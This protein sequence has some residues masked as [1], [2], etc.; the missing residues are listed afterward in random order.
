MWKKICAIVI[1]VLIAAG[2]LVYMLSRVWD[3]IGTALAAVVPL[4]PLL[5]AAA[6]VICVTAWFLR[7]RR[8]KTILNRLGTTVSIPF[9]TAC[10][11]VSQTANIVVPARLGDF[12]R[13]FILK[14]EK[15]TTYTAGFTS[16]IAERVYDILTIALLG[17]VSLPFLISLI[18]SEYSWFSWIIIGVLIMGAMGILFLLF[19]RNAHT[20]NKLLAKILE[21][22]AQFRQVS[23]SPRTFLHLTG[24][25]L[26]IWLMDVVI[27]WIAGLMFGQNINFFLV[28]FAVVIGNLVK[29]IPITPGGIATYEAAMTIVFSFGGIPAVFATLI[30]ILDH[31][32]KNLIT[33][34]GGIISLIVFGEWSVGLMKKLFR[35]GKEATKVDTGDH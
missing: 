23:S 30:P 26:V 35:E 22:F 17:L 24:I 16:L 14:H 4:W 12:V 11:F 20:K 1:P 21:I 32:I 19:M 2:I 13:M 3:D 7:G 6:C 18:P 33:I 31:L 10:I 8:Y 34:I 29:A 5:L 25:S 28:L 9:S 15:Q 27:C